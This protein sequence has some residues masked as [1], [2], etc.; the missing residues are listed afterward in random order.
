MQNSTVYGFCCVF[1][2]YLCTLF[3]HPPSLPE[4]SGEVYQAELPEQSTIILKN[5]QSKKS[6]EHKSLI[7]SQGPCHSVERLKRDGY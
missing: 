3:P 2:V 7:L 4:L 1:C 5:H 6:R